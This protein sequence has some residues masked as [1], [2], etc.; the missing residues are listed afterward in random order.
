MLDYPGGS[1]P[2]MRVFREEGRKSQSKQRTE[3]FE[4]FVWLA[5]KTEDGA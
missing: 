3:R 4:G 5:L 1:H 2:I